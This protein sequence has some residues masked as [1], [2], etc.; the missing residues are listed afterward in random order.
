MTNAEI[1][2]RLEARGF[3]VWEKL[4]NG[5]VEIYDPGL[6]QPVATGRTMREA[7][8]NFRRVRS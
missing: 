1:E 5:G 8:R 7:Y 4:F 2:E 3:K 6:V